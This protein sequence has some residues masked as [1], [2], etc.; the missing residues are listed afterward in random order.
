[1]C[2]RAPGRARQPGPDRTRASRGRSFSTFLQVTWK[3]I[4]PTTTRLSAVTYS[5]RIWLK[6]KYSACDSPPPPSLSLIRS[7]GWTKPTS[8]FKFLY[9]AADVAV[10]VSYV[11]DGQDIK[12]KGS[13]MSAAR[14]FFFSLQSCTCMTV[15]L[16]RAESCG[17]IECSMRKQSSNT[18]ATEYHASRDC[19]N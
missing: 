18:R 7:L 12:I 4:V 19:C 13:P 3:A 1:M 16:E 5:T 8:W 2:G 17:W 11:V 9:C 10:N 14:V 6:Y 15:L